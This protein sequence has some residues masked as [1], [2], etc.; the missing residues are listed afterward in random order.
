MNSRL[1]STCPAVT[2][3][4]LTSCNCADVGSGCRARAATPAK[5]QLRSPWLLSVIRSAGDVGC[6]CL[7]KIL[8]GFHLQPAGAAQALNIEQAA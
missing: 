2:R 1:L 6:F 4:D 5:E 3:R 8:R 7:N